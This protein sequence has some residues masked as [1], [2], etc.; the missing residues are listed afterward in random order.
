VFCQP[1]E[2]WAA[3]F[4]PARKCFNHQTGVVFGNVIEVVGNRPPDVKRGVV[5]QFF[6]QFDCRPGIAFEY[7]QAA[8]PG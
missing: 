7:T 3:V 5:T 2:V 6:Q 1:V 8:R 4:S